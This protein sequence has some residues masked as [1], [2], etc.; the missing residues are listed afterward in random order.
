MDYPAKDMEKFRRKLEEREG[1]DTQ[2]ADD[3]LVN[4]EDDFHESSFE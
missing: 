4:S 3:N 2:V 1:D